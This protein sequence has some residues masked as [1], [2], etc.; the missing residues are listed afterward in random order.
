MNTDRD[1][2]TTRNHQYISGNAKASSSKMQLPAPDSSAS[3]S[4]DATKE[5]LW[6]YC[7]IV[8]KEG[9]FKVR[10]SHRTPSCVHDL[11]E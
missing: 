2:D 9:G 7:E 10:F 4:A 8:R 5:P 1:T 6:E 3:L 11:C